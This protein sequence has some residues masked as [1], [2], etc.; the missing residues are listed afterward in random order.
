MAFFLCFI[1]LFFSSASAACNQCVLAKAAF[2]A[3]TEGLSGGACGYGALYGG[4]VAAALPSLY[5]NGEGCGA[6]Y[7]IRC[8]KRELCSRK[9]TTIVVT[10]IH[11]DKSNTTDFVLS[12]RAFRAMALL[13]RD[14][15]LLQH[16]IADIEYKRVPCNYHGKNLS[17][18][19]EEFSKP[20]NYL[21]IKVLYQGG[22][23]SIL[24]G[25]VAS[26]DQPSS[27]VSLTRN[28][29]AVWDTN[30]A[31]TG[32]LMFRF[33]I[34]SGFDTRYF[35][36]N[37]VLPANWKL[38]VIYNSTEQISDVALDGCTPCKPWK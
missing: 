8:K 14:K 5:K 29:G 13:D 37:E 32:K 23:T 12:I 16:G 11:N 15:Q 33:M 2:F 1:F 21:A 34:G 3:S 31:P 10:D 22:Q 18:R 30:N 25:D 17:L 35:Q 28:Y 24:G 26:V 27:W 19:V 36:A 20:P 4:H 6:C 9:G 38:G 7:R